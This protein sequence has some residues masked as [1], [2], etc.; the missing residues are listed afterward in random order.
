[1]PAPVADRGP[2]RQAPKTPAGLAGPACVACCLL[3]AL[4]AA[5]VVGAG[6]TAVVGRLPGIAL[7]LGVAASGTW[8][9]TQRPVRLFVRCGIRARY[10]VRLRP[11]A[12]AAQQPPL[13]S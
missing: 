11:P 3:P 8:W 5:G 2:S 4:V 1:M 10:G 13:V 7:V 9:L 6:A 12:R